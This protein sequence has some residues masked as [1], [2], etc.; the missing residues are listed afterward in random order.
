MGR[1]IS[2]IVVDGIIFVDEASQKEASRYTIG[3]QETFIG[4]LGCLSII[5]VALVAS[6]M[7]DEA[8]ATLDFGL[9]S[10]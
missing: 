4:L 5:I 7:E 3:R 2:L 10:L 6:G 8:N 1:W 9:C